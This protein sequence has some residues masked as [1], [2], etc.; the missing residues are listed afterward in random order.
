[1][2]CHCE[3]VSTC[4][5]MRTSAHQYDCQSQALAASLLRTMTARLILL[6]STTQFGM[7]LLYCSGVWSYVVGA[8][9]T[10]TFIII[11][12]ITIWA[13]IFPIVISWW[14]ALGLTVYMLATMLVRRPSHQCWESNV[15]VH[16]RH[17][18]PCVHK[19]HVWSLEVFISLRVLAPK[20]PSVSNLQQQACSRSASAGTT[21][22]S[23][24]FCDGANHMKSRQSMGT[25][26]C[27]R[28]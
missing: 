26:I 24:L 5:S 21:I 18:W 28:F 23:T 6:L 19:R 13:G 27:N 15:G 12:L 8:L 20:S 17:I 10:P 4:F 11:P 16:L 14:A 22:D 2:T 7:K 25:C 9:S 1:M 3:S